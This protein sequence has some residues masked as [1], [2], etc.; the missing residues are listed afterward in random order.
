[1][2]Y[3][4]RATVFSSSQPMGGTAHVRIP[5][6]S[7]RSVE[8]HKRIVGCAQIRVTNVDQHPLVYGLLPFRPGAAPYLM[9]GDEIKARPRWVVPQQL[10]RLVGCTESPD[11]AGYEQTVIDALCA[12]DSGELCKAVLGRRLDLEMDGPVS[13]SA[14]YQKLV[15]AEPLACHFQVP[16]PGGGTLVGATPELLLRKRGGTV[17]S[18]PLAGSA[19]RSLDPATDNQ[20]ARHVLSSAK[21]RR[22]HA[23]VVE[24][25]ADSLSPFCTTLTV[26]SEPAL[27]GTTTMW[28]LGTLIQGSLR[29]ADTSVLHMAQILQPTP[30]LCG[31]PRDAALRLIERVEPFE[32]GFFG[33]A[34][35]WCDQ[36]GNGEWSVVIRAAQVNGTRLRLFAGAGIV[37]GSDPA[38]EWQETGHKLATVLKVIK[39]EG[40]GVDGVR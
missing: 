6:F 5:D 2:T 17:T 24:T 9:T 15:D 3:A 28:H 16:L 23:L 34:V 37:A 4:E 13:P 10:P 19:P 1:M 36:R 38:A 33:G 11:R 21:D 12:I 31:T 40:L 20:N 39:D 18:H 14:I 8:S 32:R 27:V 29:A 30:A 25:L 22:E 35:G 26:P 7:Y